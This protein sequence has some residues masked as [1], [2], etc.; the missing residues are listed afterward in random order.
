MSHFGERNQQPRRD[1]RLS[2]TQGEATRTLARAA[3]VNPL[4]SVADALNV[5]TRPG[6]VV[7]RMGTGMASIVM[8]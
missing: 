7:L 5:T 2:R 6:T 4:L 8:A 1:R 3:V